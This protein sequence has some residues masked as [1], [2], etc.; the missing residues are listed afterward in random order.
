MTDQQPPKDA[1]VPPGHDEMLNPPE[2]PESPPQ[3]TPPG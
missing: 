1:E 3:H 2:P